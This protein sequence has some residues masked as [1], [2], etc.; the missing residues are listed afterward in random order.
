MFERLRDVADR[1]AEL[2]S[3]LSDPEVL[4]DHTRYTAIHRE[5]VGLRPLVE[6]W[7]EWQ[8]LRATI[9]EAQEMLR[10]PE[11]RDLAREELNEAEPRLETLEHELKLL[12]L[13]TDPLDEKNIIL[14]IRAGT[15]GDESALFAADLFNMYSRFA[16]ERG[17]RVEI[18]DASEGGAGGFKELIA[19]ISGQ[20]VYSSLKW[21][22]GTHRVQ[23]VPATETQGRIHTS[24]ATVAILAEAD[25][26]EIS[27]SPNDIRVDTFRASGAGGQ[28]VN[29]TDSAIRITHLP[30]GL[31]VSCQDEKS[32]HKNRDRAMKVLKARLFD[33]EQQ[34][35]HDARADD[36]KSQVGS[37]DRSERI[38]T[39]NFPQNRVTD[40]RI[41][42]TLYNLDDVVQGELTELIDALNTHHQ[43]E[44]LQQAEGAP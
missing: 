38:R 5:A 15:G 29:R 21:E 28:H 12:M 25:D 39:Y 19:L 23:R 26:V 32:Q 13:P 6:T 20:R 33:L 10:D 40:H 8:R 41:G 17:W 3:Q 34:R 36:R 1:Y 18:L 35:I 7:E 44:L 27:I 11:L 43:S 42:L 30:T 37:G 22:S 9:E 31:V 24:A 14:E 16:D 4:G 2:N